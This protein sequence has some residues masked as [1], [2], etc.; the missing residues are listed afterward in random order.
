MCTSWASG[1]V[2]ELDRLSG[3]Q[4]RLLSSSRI[5]AQAAIVEHPARR[6]LVVPDACIGIVRPRGRFVIAFGREI[7][8]LWASS[9]VV[10]GVRPFGPQPVIADPGIKGVFRL[11]VADDSGGMQPKARSA[12]Y[13]RLQGVLPIRWQDMPMART[14]EGMTRQLILHQKENL[15]GSGVLKALHP[16]A[17]GHDRRIGGNRVRHKKGEEA[18]QPGCCIHRALHHPVAV[19]DDRNDGPDDQRN[20]DRAFYDACFCGYTPE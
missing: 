13:I 17:Y 16:I 14:A 8:A 7:F 2:C 20:P 15:N 4:R 19:I 6:D 9:L 11:S 18:L 5:F 1:L 10:R 12:L 3:Q